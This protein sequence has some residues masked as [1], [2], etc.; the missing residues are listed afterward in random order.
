VPVVAS[1]SGRA[2]V[3]PVTVTVQLV[4][5]VRL[6]DVVSADWDCGSTPRD[7]SVTL[8]VCSV[9]PAAGQGSTLVVTARGVRP[10]GTVQVSSPGD[11]DASNDTV[12]FRAGAHLLLL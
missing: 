5:P 8:L 7:R 6:M 10:E 11:P 3:Q 4:R 1:T 2:G 12:T 9:T